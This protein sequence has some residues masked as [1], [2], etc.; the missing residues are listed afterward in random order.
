LGEISEYPYTV[1]IHIY[2]HQKKTKEKRK[3]IG[4]GRKK[5]GRGRKKIG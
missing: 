5:I 1:S 2:E 4:R 3:K